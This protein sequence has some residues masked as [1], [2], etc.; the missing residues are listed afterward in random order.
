MNNILMNFQS[1][2]TFISQISTRIFSKKDII[3]LLV[4]TPW[5]SESYTRMRTPKW[6]DREGLGKRCTQSVYFRVFTKL[7]KLLNLPGCRITISEVTPELFTHHASWCPKI[8]LKILL[9]TYSWCLDAAKLITEQ[10]LIVL[11][12][13]T[14]RHICFKGKWYSVSNGQIS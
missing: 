11:P 6:I 10:K 8:P 3:F 7:K 14:L 12:V 13:C 2:K 9:K 5:I 1:Q 4:K